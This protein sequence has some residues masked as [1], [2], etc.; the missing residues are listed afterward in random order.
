MAHE[1][2]AVGPENVLAADWLLPPQQEI[3]EGARMVGERL[4]DI[5]SGLV[6][7]GMP[8]ERFH[9]IGFGVGAHISGVAGHYLHSSIGRITGLDPFAPM[10]VE[11]DKSFS[12]D[13][14]DAQYVDVIHTNFNPN[15]PVAAL[16]STLPMGHVDFYIGEGHQLPGCPQALINREKYLLCSHH[17]AFKLFT[18]SIQAPCP[19][20]AF[21]CQAVVDFRGALCTRCHLPGLHVCPQ[22]VLQ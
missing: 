10:F 1:L 18:S 15:E 6:E 7:A 20:T 11:A 13:Y 16:G 19:L 17:R 22:L 5:I 14:T 4:A 9:L 3:T 12:L 2:L 8:P 21:P